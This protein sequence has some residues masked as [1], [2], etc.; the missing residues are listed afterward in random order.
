MANDICITTHTTDEWVSCVCVCVLV[1]RE[2]EREGG[3]REIV[4]E[5]GVI[6]TTANM[7]TFHPKPKEC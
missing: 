1:K 2:R 3:E 4:T 6:V 5:A 7:P